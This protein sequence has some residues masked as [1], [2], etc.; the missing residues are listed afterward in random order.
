MSEEFPMSRAKR[1]HKSRRHDG[2][3]EPNLTISY[4]DLIANDLFNELY[5]D[6]WTERRDGMRDA[7]SDNTKIKVNNS[8]FGD[9]EDFEY[10]GEY[11]LKRIRMNNKLKRYTKVR[12]ARKLGRSHFI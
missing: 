6:D 9:Y 11:M 12:L 8:H 5:Y 10:M 2:W 7:Y 3:V 1:T 4:K